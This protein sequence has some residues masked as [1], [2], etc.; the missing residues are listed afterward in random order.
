MLYD[1]WTNFDQFVTYSNTFDWTV[2]TNSG[3]SYIRIRS[4]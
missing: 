3:T 4:E 1:V 2:P